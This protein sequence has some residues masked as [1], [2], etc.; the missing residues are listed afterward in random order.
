MS[1]VLE[2]IVANKKLELIERKSI[3]SQQIISSELKPS[4]RSLFDALNSSHA[5]FILECKKASP[6]RGLIRE[7]FNLQKIIACYSKYAS[8]ISVLT[9]NKYFQ[10]SFEY[11]SQVS[12][13]VTQPV[14]AKDFFIDPYQVVEARHHGADAIL[15]MLSV[16]NDAQYKQLAE[17]AASLNL[18]VLTEVH[19]QKEMERAIAL[20]AKIIGINNRNLKDLSINIETTP[21][22]LSQLTQQQKFGRLFISESGISNNQQVRQLAKEVNGFLVGSSIMAKQDIEQ[23]C[24]A[25]I[26]GETKICGINEIEVAKCADKS[27]AV[28][29]GLIFYPPSPR[30]VSIKKAK[31]IIQSVPLQWVG[32]F[33]NMPL[34]EL[35]GIAETLQLNVLQLHGIEDLEYI[36][37]VKDKLPKVQ[38]WKAIRVNNSLSP[39][40]IELF[41][42]PAIDRL[43]FDTQHQQQLGGSGETFDWRCLANL[44]KQQIVLAGGLKQSNIL[45]ATALNCVCLDINSGVESQ[46]GKKSCDKISAIFEQIRS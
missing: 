1:N 4:Q 10:G 46:P 19:D 25:L 9:D 31:S 44:N 45:P 41:D 39:R 12:Q 11:L 17:A 8:A 21:K 22:L 18:D 5:D 2:K 36:T 26:F 3:T 29:G 23:Q 37:R 43:L 27:G 33:V 38:I 40:Q 34:L 13:T 16:L 7:D 20:D 15:L 24:K 28:Y 14:L 42:H 30:Y 6:S 32:V 35:V